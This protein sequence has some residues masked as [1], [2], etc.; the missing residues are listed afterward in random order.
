MIKGSF[1][2]DFSIIVFPKNYLD[3]TVTKQR[4]NIRTLRRKLGK[5]V[6]QNYNAAFS[7]L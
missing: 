7:H 1:T 4:S 6:K 3:L 5:H 2:I